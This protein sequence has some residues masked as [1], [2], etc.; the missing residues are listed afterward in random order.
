MAIHAGLLLRK[1]FELEAVLA[2]R[3]GLE[4]M[5]LQASWAAGVRAMAREGFQHCS[6]SLLLKA[7][8]LLALG[9]CDNGRMESYSYSPSLNSTRMQN[10]EY[11]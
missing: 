3:L 8:L 7:A 11:R 4:S 2:V 5:Q 1:Q 9:G 6:V 10:Q